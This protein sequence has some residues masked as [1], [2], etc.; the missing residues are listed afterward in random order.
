MN[1]SS[2]YFS[3]EFKAIGHPVAEAL[4]YEQIG[5]ILVAWGQL[6]QTISRHT[7]VD[8]DPNNAFPTGPVERTF[9]KRWCR[10]CL[11]RE[12]SCNPTKRHQFNTFREDVLTLSDMRDDLAHNVSSIST[13]EDERFRITATR[14]TKT[15]WRHRFDAWT[16]KYARKPPRHRPPMP[17]GANQ[18]VHYWNTHIQ[19]L[20]QSIATARQVI[21]LIRER[22][23]LHVLF[24][25][26]STSIIDQGL[27]ELVRAN[28]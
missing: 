27:T 2:D 22:E 11:K 4:A 5:R 16:K 1:N 18:D 28:I 14:W 15:D 21:A 26:P 13:L 6:D 19:A 9:Y 24:D 25:P 7:W 3:R 17:R 23:S 8:N 12:E 10:W 20:A